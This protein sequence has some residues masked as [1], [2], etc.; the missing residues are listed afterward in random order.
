MDP[1]SDVEGRALR[2]PLLGGDGDRSLDSIRRSTTTLAFLIV[3]FGSSG[4]A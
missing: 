2:P 1:F 3:V 4:L